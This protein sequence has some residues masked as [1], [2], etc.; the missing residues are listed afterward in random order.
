M[1]AHTHTHTQSYPDEEL[2]DFKPVMVTLYEEYLTLAKR[3][4]EVMGYALKLEVC[5]HRS[6]SAVGLNEEQILR[7][8]CVIQHWTN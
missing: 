7:L 8:Q 1:H 2:P 4:M 5:E 3:L 6:L